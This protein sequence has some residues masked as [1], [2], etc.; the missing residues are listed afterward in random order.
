MGLPI[1]GHFGSSC[2]NSLAGKVLH[3]PILRHAISSLPDSDRRRPLTMVLLSCLVA[4]SLQTDLAAQQ[5]TSSHRLLGN[6]MPNLS[7]GA[8]Q[9]ELFRRLQLLTGAAQAKNEDLLKSLNS[10]P[11]A[12]R[13]FQ[14][15]M[16]NLQRLQGEPPGESPQDSQNGR[17]PNGNSPTRRDTLG[18]EQNPTGSRPLTPER[19]LPPG[20]V[21]DT[22]SLDPS[23]L[24]RIA[25]QM[26]LPLGD[27]ENPQ[28]GDSTGQRPGTQGRGAERQPGQQPGRGLI[29][30]EPVVGRT[31]R[32]GANSARSPDG[33]PSDGELSTPYAPG[34]SAEPQTSD[35]V[36]PPKGSIQSLLDWFAGKDRAKSNGSQPKGPARPAPGTSGPGGM[37]DSSE[38]PGTG[39]GRST[40]G[41]R[42]SR[43]DIPPGRG[44]GSNNPSVAGNDSSPGSGDW[45][46][47]G[48]IAPPRT[49]G[50]DGS[51]GSGRDRP[52]TTGNL[53]RNESA[54]GS[55][56]SSGL[57][58][59]GRDSTGAT[60][61]SGD[62]EGNDASSLRDSIEAHLKAQREERLEDVR[63]SSKS[64]RQKLLDIAKLAR[65]ESGR[66]EISDDPDDSAASDGLQSAFVDALQEA[67]K[68]L[69]E[70]VDEFAVRDRN[71]FNRA[72][73]D[74]GRTLRE[75]ERGSFGSIGRFGDRAGDLISDIVEPVTVPAS[76]VSNVL[77]G[78]DAVDFSG[79]FEL[80]LLTVIGFGVVF[81]MQQRRRV[82]G[83]QQSMTSRQTAAPASMDNRQDI[84]QAFHELADRCPAVAADWWTHDRAAEALAIAKPSVDADVRQ[85]AQLYEQARYLPDE[86]S[87]TDEQLAAAKAAW[88]R[89]R[90]S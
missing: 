37:I 53:S 83:T 76:P 27:P 80:L 87:L 86:S 42:G 1:K 15:A 25:E 79:S 30:P 67:T 29:A 71:R 75:P 13:S 60:D 12:M 2:R 32:P 51:P 45:F 85:L 50:D 63:E 66:E 69:A 90:K 55:S 74:R 58:T 34:S 68:G 43:D 18:S 40:P 9:M 5:S 8:S 38:P 48:G 31:D 20:S 22:G 78:T 46:P 84:V 39:V 33:T 73:S 35:A 57:T 3:V 26:G 41:S 16:Q 70:H 7:G 11:A 88:L 49:S 19:S 54:P 14:D 47:G 62:D 23:V 28:P 6:G 81:W 82:A 61:G 4:W 65:S 72:Q 56:S 89:C 77:S 24:K 59:R 52:G 44:P 64:L 10:D 17:L 21:D 36:D